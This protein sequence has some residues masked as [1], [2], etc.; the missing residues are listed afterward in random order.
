[1]SKVT[2]GTVGYRTYVPGFSHEDDISMLSCELSRLQ[3]E[4]A[5][6]VRK[7]KAA[8]AALDIHGVEPPH[9]CKKWWRE[10]K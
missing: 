8:L 7:L 3:A 5:S 10:N 6:L 1:M 2:P 9:G 4:N